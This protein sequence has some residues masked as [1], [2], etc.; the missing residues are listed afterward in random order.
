MY[1]S[2][3]YVGITFLWVIDKPSNNG[4]EKIPAIGYVCSEDRVDMFTYMGTMY[5]PKNG[6]NT[7]QI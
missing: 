5:G 6:P 3:G 7:Y 1:N 2:D 4:Y